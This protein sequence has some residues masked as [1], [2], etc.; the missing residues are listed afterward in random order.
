MVSDRS[1]TTYLSH[2]EL[3]NFRSLQFRLTD[4]S[5]L[6]HFVLDTFLSFVISTFGHFTKTHFDLWAF[7]KNVN[8]N[9]GLFGTMSFRIFMGFFI[10]FDLML[11]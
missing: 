7:R 10:L 5:I 1:R 9:L 4:F 3:R 2:F 11:F 8:S 6:C